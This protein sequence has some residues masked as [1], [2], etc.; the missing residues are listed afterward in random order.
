VLAMPGFSLS[1]QTK[2]F[3]KVTYGGFSMDGD[4]DEE[5]EYN[6]NEED[7]EDKE[8]EEEINDGGMEAVFGESDS[9]AVENIEAV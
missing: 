2:Q 6:N 4:D 7:K 9:D 5:D 8:N 1:W 3:C